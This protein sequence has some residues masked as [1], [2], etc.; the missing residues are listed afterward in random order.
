[1]NRFLRGENEILRGYYFRKLYSVYNLFLYI[2]TNRLIDRYIHGYF[3]KSSTVRRNRAGH[4]DQGQERDVA[5]GLRVDGHI[6]LAIPTPQ[7]YGS[8]P[9]A[10]TVTVL[11]P[12]GPG[13]HGP[14]S[15]I[16]LHRRPPGLREGREN[17]QGALSALP[18]PLFHPGGDTPAPVKVR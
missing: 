6:P 10:A 12:M 9:R 2:G 4:P 3:P 13:A 15:Y 5:Q 11:H 18:A 14:G 17:C 7:G 1:M 16:F 8:R